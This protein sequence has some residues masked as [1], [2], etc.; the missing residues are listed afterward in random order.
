MHPV[1][2]DGLVQERQAEVLR[3]FG[4]TRSHRPRRNGVFRRRLG[5]LLVECGLR[6][7]AG[8]R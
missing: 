6:L 7:V 2:L 1:Q 5:W 3:Q 8:A 4:R